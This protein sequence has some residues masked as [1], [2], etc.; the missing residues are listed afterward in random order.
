[1][2]LVP[3]LF[4]YFLLFVSIVGEVGVP[5]MLSLELP[6]LEVVGVTSLSLLVGVVPLSS[7]S[8]FES[9]PSWEVGV[10]SVLLLEMGVES[11]RPEV[12]IA[13]LSLLVGVVVVPPSLLSLIESSPPWRRR[14]PDKALRRSISIRRVSLVS[15]VAS[16]V[17]EIEM[18]AQGD[19]RSREGKLKTRDL[20]FT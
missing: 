2:K 13:S 11:P 16:K 6:R 12:G 20:K 3:P 15:S 1:M 8:L 5:S 4:L 10:A 17:D 19:H 18:C 14:R 7:L 9:L